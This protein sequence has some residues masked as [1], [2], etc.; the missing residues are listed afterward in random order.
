MRIQ[1]EVVHF[2]TSLEALVG[3]AQVQRQRGLGK[4]HFN[5]KR[6]TSQWSQLLISQTSLSRRQSG[7]CAPASQLLCLP[8]RLKHSVLRILVNFD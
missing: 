1:R 2:L 7:W 5:G 3:Y 8:A 6:L 4:K